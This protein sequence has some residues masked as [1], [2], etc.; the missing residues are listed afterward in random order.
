MEKI[1]VT[2]CAGFIGMH[3]CE[4]L[5][6]DGY[7]ILGV[8][9]L[10]DYYNPLLKQ[11]RLKKLTYYENFKFLCKDISIS[12]DVQKAVREYKPKKVINLA[13]QAGIRY[14]LVNPKLYIQANVVGFMNI[15]E[16]CIENEVEALSM[17]QAHQFMGIIK[18]L[19]SQFQ[20]QLIDLFQY[21]L[22]P[23][24]QMNLWHILIIIFMG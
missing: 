7:D 17:H 20:I 13:A 22:L 3:L 24:D 4:D 14:S 19:H 10:N 1:L 21:M 9:D 6:N 23:K 15:L 12:M 11:E 2:G 8:D 5:L 16:A 18:R